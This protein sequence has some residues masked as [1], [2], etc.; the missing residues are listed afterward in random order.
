MPSQD[1]FGLMRSALAEEQAKYE[2][3]KGPKYC[4]IEYG[5]PAKPASQP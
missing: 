2:D 3:M 5:P 4:Q 1:I